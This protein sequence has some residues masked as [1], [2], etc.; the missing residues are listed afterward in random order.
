MCVVGRYNSYN[1]L[2]QHL[3]FSGNVLYGLFDMIW[4]AL[5]AL[6]FPN[7]LVVDQVDS[8][9]SHESVDITS[10]I[11]NL[12]EQFNTLQTSII[13]E[14][15]TKPGITVQKLLNQLTQLPLVLRREYESAIAK[16]IPSMR[17]ETK[18]DEL[19]IHLNPL[20]S[21][22]DYGL[23]EY[24]IKKFG[25]DAL[26][27]DM[28]SYCGEIAVFMKETTI[29][30]L[31][32]FFPSTH[33]APP[34]FSLI[35][36]EIGDNIGKCTLEEI[37]ILRKKY[38]HGILLSE[39]VFYCVSLV[40]SG[41]GGISAPAEIHDTDTLIKAS[42]NGDVN[43]VK[44][45]LKT[46][47]LRKDNEVSVLMAASENGH[48]EVINL[49]LDHDIDVNS[50]NENRK[51][52]LMIA[53]QHGYVQVVRLLLQRG[54]QPNL[55][56]SNGLSSL[57]MA[58]QSSHHDIVQVLLNHGAEMDVRSSNGWTALMYAGWNNHIKV[59]ETLLKHGVHV[60]K[61]FL[62]QLSL[63]RHKEVLVML[64]KPLGML[65]DL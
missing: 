41:Q 52:A 60:D 36:A 7:T 51:S 8:S 1:M 12:E 26:K 53:S 40:D 35:K 4:H 38:C 18:V 15:S 13:D 24:F 45:L 56:D 65:S 47:S 27:R 64:N 63:T 14:L 6:W 34:N 42:R 22:I 23:I 9:G 55:K 44:E 43:A 30:Q 29:E 25:S 37:N 28:R 33:E 54:A 39:M 3:L 50:C 32:D 48:D 49:L 17:T 5:T 16:R 19:F 21:F 11:E 58:S 57:M 62:T 61:G 10:K 31:A 46:S 20:T 59:L 2:L